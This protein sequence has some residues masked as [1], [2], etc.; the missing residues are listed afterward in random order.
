MPSKVEGLARLKARWARI[1]AAMRAQVR[2]AIDTGA[3]ELVAFQQR[4]APVDDGTLRASI[5]KE[6]GPHM[7]A[8][9]VKAGSRKAFY[10]RFV[11]FGVHG[12][13]AHPFFYPPYR[14][15]KRRIRSRIGRA[16]G[17]A[18]RGG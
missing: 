15:L 13:P 8:V 17:K 2:P 4:L 3:D 16:I 9:D 18:V 10:A 6:E 14:A 12:R 1:P 7:L 11:E 5:R